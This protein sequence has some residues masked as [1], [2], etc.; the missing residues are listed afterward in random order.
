MSNI[1]TDKQIK[2]IEELTG[3]FYSEYDSS[4]MGVPCFRENKLPTILWLSKGKA[5]YTKGVYHEQADLP[6]KWIAPLAKILE[7]SNA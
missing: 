7:D 1:L 2:A 6:I 4:G 3:L 5:N